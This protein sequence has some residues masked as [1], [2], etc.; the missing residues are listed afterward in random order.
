MLPAGMALV[1]SPLLQAA[2]LEA[3]QAFFIALIACKPAKTPFKTLLDSLLQAGKS[4]V[5]GSRLLLLQSC[6]ALLI[7]CQGCTVVCV[8]IICLKADASCVQLQTAGYGQGG[9]ALDSAVHRCAVHSS[10]QQADLV[11]CHKAAA[12]TAGVA[13][14]VATGR[15]LPHLACHAV[16]MKPCLA[17]IWTAERRTASLLQTRADENGQRLALLTIGEI[18]RSTDLSSYSNL[19]SIILGVQVDQNSVC[20]FR[21]M[22][23]GPS[24]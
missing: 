11:D 12:N 19:Q 23:S 1:T 17:S 18:G 10:W 9:A 3:L 20:C 22:C 13:V 2:P 8:C 6:T 5:R 14:S 15:S 21:W 7:C 24:A 4:P 16:C